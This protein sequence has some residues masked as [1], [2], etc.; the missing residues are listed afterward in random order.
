M[1]QQPPQGPSPPPPQGPSP[2]PPQGPPPPPHQIT[3]IDAL[4]QQLEAENRNIEIQ[5]QSIQRS[6]E[7]LQQAIGD[8]GISHE[9]MQTQLSMLLNKMSE[10]IQGQEHLVKDVSGM[11]SSNA[12]AAEALR[13]IESSRETLTSQITETKKQLAQVSQTLTEEQKKGERLT[14]VNEQLH[15]LHL[16]QV[17]KIQTNVELLKKL[18]AA[19][20]HLTAQAQQLKVETDPKQSIVG[21]YI[22]FPYLIKIR[23]AFGTFINNPQIKPK[24]T[25]DNGM[26]SQI[27]NAFNPVVNDMNE[28][29]LRSVKSVVEILQNVN[30]TLTGM[31]QV[32]GDNGRSVLPQSQQTPPFFQDY[33]SKIESVKQFWNQEG[34]AFYL[35]ATWTQEFCK[36]PYTP[37]LTSQLHD[38]LI[39]INK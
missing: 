39:K 21:I 9:M 19:I 22:H 18:D 7:G 20:Q 37:A 32:A 27:L 24:S 4:R 34:C 12:G 5:N 15:D 33:E 23:N 30:Q 13:R 2:P 36:I 16:D 10:E 3:N 17:A 26:V 31:Q 1:N 11:A 28:Q 6:N 25:I 8:L 35:V 38:L 14:Q 29:S